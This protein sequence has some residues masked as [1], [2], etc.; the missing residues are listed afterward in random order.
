MPATFRFEEKS[1]TA[2]ITARHSLSEFS[3]KLP[4]RDVIMSIPVFAPGFSMVPPG[5]PCIA[6]CA[7][8]ELLEHERFFG[9]LQCVT[10]APTASGFS[11][12][13]FL[14]LQLEE[15]LDVHANIWHL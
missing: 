10:V 1:L 5:L 3:W 9:N 4:F 7:L 2:L 15:E 13:L 6:S 8:L 12:T 11:R 14:F